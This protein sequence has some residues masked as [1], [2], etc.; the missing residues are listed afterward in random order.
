M[1]G[2]SL[3][4]NQL[5]N[6]ERNYAPSFIS[7]KSH[8]CEE[9]ECVNFFHVNGLKYTF[10]ITASDVLSVR[11]RMLLAYVTKVFL[12][13]REDGS[14]RIDSNLL[15]LILAAIE[16]GI[17]Q[18]NFFPSFMFPEYLDSPPCT[19]SYAVS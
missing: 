3:K 4:F 17:E 9:R 14:S 16:S 18:G 15:S 7:F 6:P 12:M 11:C 5:Q 2:L 19:Y 10:V 1:S 8:L 13:I